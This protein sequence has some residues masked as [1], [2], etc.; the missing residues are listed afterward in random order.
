MTSTR[1]KTSDNNAYQENRA[2]YYNCPI[3]NK[4]FYLPITCSPA[5]YAYKIAE[6]NPRSKHMNYTLCCSW[7]CL[8]KLK[9]QQPAKKKKLKDM[10]IV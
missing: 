4:E 5:N 7:T 9:A 2:G 6:K 1:Y 8:N 3:C 10:D